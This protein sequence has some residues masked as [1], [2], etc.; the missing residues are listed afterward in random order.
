MT[1]P[2][3]S[4]VRSS[5][6]RAFRS[7]EDRWIGGVAA[8]LARHLGTDAFKVRAAF[9]VLTILGGFGLMLYAGL[10][11]ILPTDTHL[12]IMLRL[13]AGEQPGIIHERPRLRITM[14]SRGWI[15]ADVPRTPP[16]EYRRSKPPRRP[17]RLTALG[18]E[19]LVEHAKQRGWMVLFG[20]HGATP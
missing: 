13:A 2:A 12:D 6:P 10:W 3:P 20:A 5:P 11:L 4:P 1:T 15:V 7:T 18:V 19:V 17:F 14:V 16:H 9:V 8:G